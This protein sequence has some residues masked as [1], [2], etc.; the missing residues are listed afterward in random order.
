M[1][2][3]GPTSRRG[4]LVRLAIAA[5]LLGAAS[6]AAAAGEARGDAG[7]GERLFDGTAR[8]AS[9]GPACAGCHSV[10]GLP[11]PGGG[12]MGPDLT[13]AFRK[14]GPEP[15]DTVL[16]TLFFPNM[17]PLFAGRPLTQGERT[18]LEA[19]LAAAGG[20]RAQGTTARLFL[21]G[22]ILFAVLAAAVALLGRTRLRGVR[23]SLVRRAQLPGRAR[24]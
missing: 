13:D 10:A 21:A 23:A 9:G 17:D 3:L 24:S 18:D 5:A 12:T 20:R 8:L 1:A 16:S 7:R 19:Y 2:R 22:A 11:S 6:S 4:A 14:Y 15:L